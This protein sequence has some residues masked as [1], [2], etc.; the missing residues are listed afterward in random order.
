LINGSLLYGQQA[1]EI[2]ID[3][4][5]AQSSF[6]LS[7]IA[8]EVTP[9]PLEIETGMIQNI[10]LAPECFIIVSHNSVVQF[11]LS[12]K[13]IRAIDCGGFIGNGIAYDAIKKELYVPIK[14]EIKRYDASG[15]LKKTYKLEN[16]I[17]N[18]SFSDNNLW[19]QSYEFTEDRTTYYYLSRLNLLTGKE[20]AVQLSSGNKEIETTLP[21]KSR[22]E[23]YTIKDSVSIGAS[24]GVSSTGYF[25]TYNQ[26]A[27]SSLAVDSILYQIQEQKATPLIRL[28]ITPPVQSQWD[29]SPITTKGFIGKYLFVNYLRN[30]QFY[31]YV[32]DMKSEKSYH[33]IMKMM[34]NTVKRT[35]GIEDDIF[36][37]GYCTISCPLDRDG[38]FYFIHNP[39]EVKEKTEGKIAVKEGPVIFIVKTKR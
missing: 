7:E 3:T 11:D 33:V 26:T 37:T 10:F 36:H 8:E 27:V 20:S 4:K 12:G 17:I 19:I 13:F 32:Q 16:N 22:S 28:H 35:S 6:K 5:D 14:K 15:R 39:D 25:S 29:I 24:V 1:K 34:P 23:P 38:Y 30:N 2:Y 31:L 9:V 18:C 21:F